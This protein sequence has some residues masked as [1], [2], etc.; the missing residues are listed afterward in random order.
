MSDFNNM[1]SNS[2]NR[3]SS[4]YNRR[5][6]KRRRQR[7]KRRLLFLTFVLIVAVITVIVITLANKPDT[8]IIG[9]GNIMSTLNMSSMKMGQAVF[10]L[11]MCTMNIHTNCQAIR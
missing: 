2:V 4:Y 11:M 1:Q 9:V 5:A 8:G 6:A 3:Q 7:R 10:V